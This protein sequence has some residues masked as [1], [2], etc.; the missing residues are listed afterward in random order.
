MTVEAVTKA[1][2][3]A[4][5][6]PSRKNNVEFVSGLRVVSN[7]DSSNKSPDHDRPGHFHA[8][9]KAGFDREIMEADQESSGSSED[10]ESPRSVV[11]KWP[12]YVH[13]QVLRIREEDSLIGEDVAENVK[14]HNDCRYKKMDHDH[15]I[16]LSHTPIH[17]PASPLSRSK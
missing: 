10:I 17:R 8:K 1:S 14:N 9:W 5:N 3:A 6:H 16:I 7:L 12:A 2:L 13:S 15:V 4:A 11:R